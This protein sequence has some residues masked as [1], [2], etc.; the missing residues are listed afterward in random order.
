MDARHRAIVAKGL[1][2][3]LE[4]EPMKLSRSRIKQL[5]DMDQPQYRLR[6]DP[7]RV[8][9]DVA[10]Q[11]VVVLAIVPKEETAG[12]LEIYGVKTL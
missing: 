4:H 11:T 5:R 10:G 1:K 3:Y 8:F 9:Y 2:D 12:W 6:L 7:Y